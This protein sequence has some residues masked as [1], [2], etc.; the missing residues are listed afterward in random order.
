VYFVMAPRYA[1][2]V[3]RLAPGPYWVRYELVTEREDLDPAVVLQAAAVRDS[4]QV[5][6]P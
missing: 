6:L 4:V 5:R 2:S 1:L 3:A